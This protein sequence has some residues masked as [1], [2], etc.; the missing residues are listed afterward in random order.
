MAQRFVMKPYYLP[1]NRVKSVINNGVGRYVCQL[2]RLTFRFC[3]NSPSSKLVRDFVEEDLND[4]AAANPGVVCYLEPVKKESPIVHAE[5]LNG[6]TEEIKTDRYE[7]KAEL[8]KW[9]HHLKDRSGIEI[10]ALEKPVGWVAPSV[11]GQ[12]TP[13]TNQPSM[14]NVASFPVHELSEYIDRKPS[15]TERLKELVEMQKEVRGKDGE[16]I[17]VDGGKLVLL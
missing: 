16:E 14:T 1:H 3:K 15:A 7:S 9:I 12:W 8:V 4:F 6:R 5:Y 10:E 17:I 2:Q 13:F 11:Q